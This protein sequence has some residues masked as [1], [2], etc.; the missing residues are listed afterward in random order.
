MGGG[1]NPDR[2][3]CPFRALLHYRKVTSSPQLRKG[4]R[5]LFISYKPSKP[6]EIKKATISSW[7]VKLIKIAYTVE[8]SNPKSLELHKVSAHEVRALSVS[9]PPSQ[10]IL[11]A[12]TWRAKSTFSSFYLRDIRSYLDGRYILNNSG[13]SIS[14]QAMRVG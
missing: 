3:L 5:K 10:E 12:C 6:D 9:W 7:L 2:K 4:R 13:W 1:E 11:W 14:L 8:G